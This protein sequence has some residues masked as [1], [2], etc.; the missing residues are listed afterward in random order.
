MECFKNLKIIHLYFNFSKLIIR[1]HISLAITDMY[2]VYQCHS[3][4]DRWSAVNKYQ[5]NNELEVTSA[6]SQKSKGN[7]FLKNIQSRR[8]PRKNEMARVPVLI[9][10]LNSEVVLGHAN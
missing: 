7:H 10:K 4:G 9:Q 6:F 8:S 5:G 1:H 2:I 3:C